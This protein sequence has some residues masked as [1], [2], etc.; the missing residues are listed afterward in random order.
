MLI[1]AR[2]DQAQNIL[3]ALEARD[4]AHALVR[5]TELESHLKKSLPNFEGGN[6]RS[7]NLAVSL[8]VEIGRLEKKPSSVSDI[9]FESKMTYMKSLVKELSD[10]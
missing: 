10:L 7:F 2:G 1:Q 5:A 9:T 6:L 8:R 3:T 4:F